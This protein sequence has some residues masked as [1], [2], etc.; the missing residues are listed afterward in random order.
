MKIFKRVRM[1]A[2]RRQFEADLAEEVRIHRELAA[3][4]G[5][6]FGPEALALENSRAVWGFGWVD[7][8]RQDVRYALRGFRKSPAFALTVVGTI[9]LGL[10]LNTTMFTVFD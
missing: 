7:G 2:Q 8:L 9:G 4:F 3:E 10:G 5:R 6:Q 1:W